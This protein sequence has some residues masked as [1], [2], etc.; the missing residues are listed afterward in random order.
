MEFHWP[1]DRIVILIDVIIKQ[2]FHVIYS[3]QAQYLSLH[4]CYI[5]TQLKEVVTSSIRSCPREL[6]N[7]TGFERLFFTFPFFFFFFVFIWEEAFFSK[8]SLADSSSSDIMITLS[9]VVF[10]LYNQTSSSETL[11]PLHRF[12]KFI[13][14]QFSMDTK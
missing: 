5:D 7:N 2:I 6:Q 8:A 1:V 11:S 3:A 10:S 4:V 13:E 9:A 12:R 14:R